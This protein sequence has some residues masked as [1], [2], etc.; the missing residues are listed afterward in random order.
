MGMAGLMVIYGMG[1]ALFLASDALPSERQARTL[2]LLRLTRLSSSELLLG[3]LVSTGLGAL[4]GIMAFSLTLALAILAGGVTIGEY[5]RVVALTLNAVFLALGIGLLTSCLARESRTA[6]ILGLALLLLPCTVPVL[7]HAKQTTAAPGIPPIHL[8]ELVSPLASFKLADLAIAVLLGERLTALYSGAWWL[9]WI[10][11]TLLGLFIDSYALTWLGLR[12]GMSALN[13][14]RAWLSAVAWVLWLP[15]FMVASLMALGGV[16]FN[17][18]VTVGSFDLVITR[19]VCG[20]FVTI[21][22]TAWAIDQ[23]RSHRRESLASPQI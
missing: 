19:M 9:G 13:T 4:Q 23:L 3:K 5:L 7:I 6:A 17:T 22:A 12:L 10:V 14:T 18:G 11:T 15:W 16:G 1:M 2:E 21:G 8:W 20:L